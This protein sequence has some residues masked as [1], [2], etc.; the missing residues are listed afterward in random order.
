MKRSLRL[1]A[2]LTVILAS[3][4][5]CPATAPGQ[6]PV[7]VQAQRT[8]SN[9]RDTLDLLFN[10][11]KD[12]AALIEQKLPGTHAVVDGIK[13]QAKIALPELLKAIDTYAANKDRAAIDKWEAVV[14][15]L[16]ESAK[17]IVSNLGKQGI[18]HAVY[19]IDGSDVPV[20][21]GVS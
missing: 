7:L 8:Y 16:L 20:L 6:D 18:V 9:A 5:A 11:E 21:G 13:T 4:T 2:A 14:R 19:W 1:A 15:Q 10:L 17:V 12:N 3:L